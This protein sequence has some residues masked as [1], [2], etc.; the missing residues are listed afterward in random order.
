[1]RSRLRSAGSGRVLGAWRCGTFGRAGVRLSVCERGGVREDVHGALD[2]GSLGAGYEVGEV[3][4]EEG[5]GL[6]GDILD[7]HVGCDVLLSEKRGE[8]LQ[9]LGFV[10]RLSGSP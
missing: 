10:R 8:D 3:T 6:G 2:R 7:G 1:M 4:R 5:G 9:P